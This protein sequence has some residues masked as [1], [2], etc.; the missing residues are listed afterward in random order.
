MFEAIMWMAVGGVFTMLA[1]LWREMEKERAQV[2]RESRI[3][4]R[5]LR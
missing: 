4:L 3:N 2:I 1:V 5:D